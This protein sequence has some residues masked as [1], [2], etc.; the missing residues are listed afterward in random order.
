MVQKFLGKV[1]RNSGNWWIFEMQTIQP[2]IPGGKLN[3]KKTCGKNFPKIWVFVARS[4]SVLEYLEDAVPPAT[5][6]CRKFTL[7]VLVEW[8]A[9]KGRLPITKS[10]QKIRLK[11]KWN[12][13]CRVVPLENFRG[14][15][16]IWKGSLVF[17]DGQKFVFHLLKPNVGVS[18]FRG[19]L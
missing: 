10:F 18:G 4:S 8:N 7:D 6:S 1:S 16:I 3:G 15:R 5:G 12:T 9:P 2:K 19:R 13:A 17:P 11:S 14:Q